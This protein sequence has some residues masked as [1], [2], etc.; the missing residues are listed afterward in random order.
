MNLPKDMDQTPRITNAFDIDIDFFCKINKFEYTD[1]KS[2]LSIFDNKGM[3][4]CIYHPKQLLNYFSNIIFIKFLEEFYVFH[5]NTIHSLPEFT[6]NHMYDSSFDY[7][8]DLS[9]VNKFDTLNDNYKLIIL[10][11]IG[12]EELG[13]DLINYIIKLTN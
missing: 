8:C 9:I 4:G 10:V 3:S 2:A 7:L 12:N 11:F 6:R 5:G 13:I 1:Q